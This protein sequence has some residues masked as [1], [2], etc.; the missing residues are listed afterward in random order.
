[1]H[2]LTL[3]HGLTLRHVLASCAGLTLCQALAF[4]CHKLAH[5]LK[6]ILQLNLVSRCIVSR[7]AQVQHNLR[8][9]LTLGDTL[10]VCHAIT[11]IIA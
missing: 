4:S 9:D 11:C 2:I 5:V 10:T 3:A 7:A 1:M 8:Y 6:P